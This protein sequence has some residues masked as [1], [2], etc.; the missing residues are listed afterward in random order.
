MSQPP[1]VAASSARGS[2]NAARLH[3]GVAVQNSILR[4][5][6]TQGIVILNIGNCQFVPFSDLPYTASDGR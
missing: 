3:E 1:G 4:N 6:L 2:Q 5:F